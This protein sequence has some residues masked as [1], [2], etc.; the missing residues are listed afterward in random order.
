MPEHHAVFHLGSS[1][2]VSHETPSRDELL[3]LRRW[4]GSMGSSTDVLWP[5][6]S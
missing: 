1:T 4:V 3:S 6:I 2:H 5:P